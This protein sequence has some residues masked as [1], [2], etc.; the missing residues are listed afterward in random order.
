MT[1]MHQLRQTL[2]RLDCLLSD[3]GIPPDLVAEI[4]GLVAQVVRMVNNADN[5]WQH[6][7][8]KCEG[9]Q[10][11]FDLL[12]EVTLH[13]HELIESQRQQIEGQRDM[14]EL[15]RKLPLL[16]AQQNGRWSKN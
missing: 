5:Q 3:P 8:H 9:M 4:D 7:R 13:D 11:A 6:W 1:A 2:M 12:F 16:H 15:L 10:Q 14:L